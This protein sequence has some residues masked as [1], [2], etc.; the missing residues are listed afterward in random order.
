MPHDAL[1]CLALGRC[2][3]YLDSY[4]C[5]EFHR[6]KN[7]SNPTRVH[8]IFT[9]LLFGLWALALI[10]VL[11]HLSVAFC[12][13][14]RLAAGGE[15]DLDRDGKISMSERGVAC[16]SALGKQTILGTATRLV[17]VIIPWPFYQ[18]LFVTCWE[19]K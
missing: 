2:F 7:T 8:L 15:G 12:Q 4:F 16:A 1:R 13:Q 18:A 10:A 19:C 9:I 14:L 6:L 3:R 11:L 17:L 5:S